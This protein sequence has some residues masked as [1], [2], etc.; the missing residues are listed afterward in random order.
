MEPVNVR[1]EW[2]CPHCGHNNV[3]YKPV[4]N[5]WGAMGTH[6]M[7]CD[8]EDG[9]CDNRF[10]IQVRAY[11]RVRVFTLTEVSDSHPEDWGKDTDDEAEARTD[12]ADPLN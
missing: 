12:Y 10:A 2:R 4:E 6:L 9:G 5:S 8:V 1:F 7:Y 11:V 3:G